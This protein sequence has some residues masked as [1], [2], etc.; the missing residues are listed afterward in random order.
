V[1]AVLEIVREGSLQAVS[2]PGAAEVAARAGVSERTVF[3]HFA[4]LDSLFLAAA[5]RMRPI[6]TTYLGPRPDSPDL[7]DRITAIV[8][9]RGKLYEDIAPV[10]RVAIYLS[11][12]QPV[13]LAQLA[14]SHAAARAQIADVFAPE[15]SRLDRRRR[16]LM[17]DALDLA[18]S[19]SS[20]EA[21]RTTQGCSTE[22]TRL[23][24]TEAM[25]ALLA[26]VPR[27]RRR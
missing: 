9:L 8:R 16:L 21:L 3:R 17:L 25:T 6:Q 7:V 2:L 12:T 5:A 13:L 1:D 27:A 10:R 14:Q 24:I 11:H 22:R 20:W 23:V 4:D 18:A 19:W 15:L 26:T